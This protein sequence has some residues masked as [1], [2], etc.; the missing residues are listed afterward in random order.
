MEALPANVPRRL[1]V[2]GLIDRE[3]Q[4]YFHTVEGTSTHATVIEAISS[5]IRMLPLRNWRSS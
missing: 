1:N 3:N 5:F 4:G 2:I